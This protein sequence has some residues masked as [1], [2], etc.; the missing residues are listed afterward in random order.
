MNESSGKKFIIVEGED[1]YQPQTA[2][3]INLEEPKN[4]DA[5]LV[6]QQYIHPFDERELGDWLEANYQDLME[7][8]EAA[9]RPE[10]STQP[11]DLEVWETARILERKKCKF[12][13]EKNHFSYLMRVL[14]EECFSVNQNPELKYPPMM[15]DL[16]GMVPGGL[17]SHFLNFNVSD[18]YSIKTV[19]ET[20]FKGYT[21][22]D[23]MQLNQ[24]DNSSKN[25]RLID[26]ISIIAIN[27]T[28]HTMREM[29]LHSRAI[30][31]VRLIQQNK[32]ITYPPKIDSVGF[33]LLCML[34]DTPEMQMIV[35]D[36]TLKEMFSIKKEAVT[37]YEIFTFAWRYFSQRLIDTN[38]T[39]K[40]ETN[41]GV[42]EAVGK[43][44]QFRTHPEL[45]I[46]FKYFSPSGYINQNS[47]DS[48]NQ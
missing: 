34:R 30:Q 40:F 36:P 11:D 7:Q 21:L 31:L 1:L 18:G 35:E 27:N 14:Y 28:Y 29:F 38:G 19:I 26:A 8:I 22:K 44:L 46:F 45:Q 41:E 37:R 39:Y 3:L 2:K 13:E 33:R 42:K 10:I 15:K 17:L 43:L 6:Q 47:V 48:E 4:N 5:E 32:D 16:L 9:Q 25:H 12:F 23:V 20:N 24:E